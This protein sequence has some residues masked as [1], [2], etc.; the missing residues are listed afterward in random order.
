MS[1]HVGVGTKAAIVELAEPYDRH[2][3]PTKHSSR[4]C[5]PIGDVVILDRA[6][7]RVAQQHIARAVAVDIAE[8]QQLPIAADR[9]DLIIMASAISKSRFAGWQAREK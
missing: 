6:I 7:V 2:S 1:N 8:A 4:L 9:R 3:S 5:L